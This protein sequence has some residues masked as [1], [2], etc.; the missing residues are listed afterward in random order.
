[1]VF[2]S[3]TTGRTPE[4]VF[5]F[6]EEKKRAK[7]SIFSGF[8]RLF[9]EFDTLHYI[10]IC[11]ELSRGLT[12][13]ESFKN[14]AKELFDSKKWEESLKLYQEVTDMDPTNIMILWNHVC[15]R[16]KLENFENSVGDTDRHDGENDTGQA[17][18]DA[19]EFPDRT[20]IGTKRRN[21]M[22]PSGK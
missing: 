7:K 20:A 11:S 17:S 14:E 8:T 6:H 21:R 9:F 19:T 13:D 12:K 18:A 22:Y 10:P 3:R 4:N 15:P 5:S 2:H 1:M 16:I